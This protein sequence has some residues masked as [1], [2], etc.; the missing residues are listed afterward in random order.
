MHPDNK[1]IP[2]LEKVTACKYIY[3][4][5]NGNL[6]VLWKGS[7]LYKNEQTLLYFHAQF[8]NVVKLVC[9]H[10]IVALILVRAQWH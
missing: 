4:Y 6:E 7:R 5:I 10:Q 9:S 3:I 1:K 8:S 2:F